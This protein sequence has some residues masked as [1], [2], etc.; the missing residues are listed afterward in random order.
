MKKVFSLVIAF[1]LLSTTWLAAQK[2]TINDP[3]AW[4]LNNHWGLQIARL[5]KGGNYNVPEDERPIYKQYWNKPYRLEATVALEEMLETT[6]NKAT[7]QKVN[8]PTLL[9]YFYKDEEFQD[10]VVKVS[11][12]KEMFKQ[13]ATADSLKRSIALPA[14]GNHVIASPIKSN[15]IAGVEKETKR[16]LAEVI[17][18]AEKN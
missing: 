8:Q 12:M 14:T 3:N 15:D 2:T 13:L 16:F 7:F 17:H 5:V 10:P 4:I 18:L 6:M 11:A 9:L 1:V